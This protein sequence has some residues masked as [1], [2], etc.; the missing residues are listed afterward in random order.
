MTILNLRAVKKPITVIN[1]STTRAEILIY[2]DVG[3]YYEDSVRASE[4]SKGLS[5]LPS[6][7]NEIDVR[8][9]SLGGCCMEGTS[10]Y[11]RLKNHKAKVNIYVDSMAASIASIIAMAGDNIYMG[12]GA[13]IM[14]HDP[15][16]YTAGNSRDLMATIERLDEVTEQLVSVYQK[17]TGLGRSEIKE[18][19]ANETFFDAKQSI[20]LGFATGMM[21]DNETLNFAASLKPDRAVWMRK[22][23]DLSLHN[24]KVNVEIDN[25]LKSIEDYI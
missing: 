17:R 7:V 6:T 9:S 16:T 12:E 18:Y 15:W 24:E 23:P 25:V 5:S 11:N 2:G 21:A 19:M 20:E 13:E 3:G 8:I 4:F 22:K 10:I 14:I 1:K